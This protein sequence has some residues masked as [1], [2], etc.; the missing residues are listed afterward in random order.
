[1]VERELDYL[2][3]YAWS[4][5][6]RVGN[7]AHNQI[8]FDILGG[9][10][11]C[12]SGHTRSRDSLSERSWR[13]VIQAVE[14]AMSSWQEPDRG[15]WEIRSD[16]RHFTFSKVM[17]WVALDRGARLA[18]L[19]GEAWRADEWRE[20]ANTIHADICAN[21][22]SSQGYFAQSYGSDQLDASLLLLATLGF[23]PADDERIRATVLAIADQLADGA[24]VY[25][26]LTD[27]TDDGLNSE[28]EGTF[29][30]CSFWLVSAL[31][32]IGELDR[33]RTHCERLIGAASNLGLYGEELDPKTVR[34]LG[35]FP[36]A[37]THLALINA[38]VSLIEAERT[39]VLIS[40][41]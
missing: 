28:A 3:G 40:S 31:I 29:T 8:Q 21:A 13:I 9:V 2:S 30:V 35:N 4:Q 17:C 6:V 12:I 32:S 27:S 26:Y 37:L 5:P 18:T 24:F 23:L 10:V 16:P 1:V 15:I 25:R 38:L 39:A 19:R 11:D 34:H 41:D 36:Q 14:V 20:T 33:A 7:A 22:L